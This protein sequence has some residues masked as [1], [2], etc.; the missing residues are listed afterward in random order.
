MFD[1]IK[2]IDL[3]KC[4]TMLEKLNVALLKYKI[5]LTIISVCCKRFLITHIFKSCLMQFSILR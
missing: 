3:F 4:V 5:H 2:I 1:D